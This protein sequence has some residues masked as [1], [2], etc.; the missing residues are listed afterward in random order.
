MSTPDT[1]GQASGGA[2]LAA[3]A[4]V[5]ARDGRLPHGADEAVA[6]AGGAAVVVGSGAQVGAA[7]LAGAV[8]EREKQDRRGKRVG[9]ILTGGNVDLEIYRNVLAEAL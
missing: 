3:V 1:L 9:I 4:V 6:E 7:A 5:V 2:P 8:K